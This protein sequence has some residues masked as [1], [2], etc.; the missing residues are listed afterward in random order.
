MRMSSLAVPLALGAL[1]V[2]AASA[3]RADLQIDITHGV[4]DPIPI[5][6]V[7]F[8]RSVPLDAAFD[9]AAVVQHDL[10]GSGRF[11]T[12]E[13]R[14]IRTLP[15]RASEVVAADWHADGQDY[16][17]VGRVSAGA[18]GG[19][20]L[21][22]DCDL[23]NVLTGQLLGS[24]RVSASPAAGRSAAHQISDFVFAKIIG[25]RGAF[26]TRIAYVAVEGSA[27]AQHFQLIVADADGESPRIILESSQ[28]IM[29][30]SWSADGQ[31]L[32]YVSFENRV[33]AVASMGPPPGLPMANGW[34]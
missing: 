26:A 1:A 30:P 32:A 3:A 17:L 33:S 25:T 15:Q 10:D 12:M 31:W 23:I 24:T 9:P 16:V 20:P 27:P 14:S 19:A 2:L 6:I 5:A 13:R 18:G 7:P 4:S 29:S 11:H 21:T 8:A 22:I 34:R 28:P